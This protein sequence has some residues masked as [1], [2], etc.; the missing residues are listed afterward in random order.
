MRH[1]AESL[2]HVPQRGRLAVARPER[3]DP[4]HE[5]SRDHGDIA[6]G[7]GEEAPA[8]ADGGHQ[9]SGHG[10]SHDAGAVEGRRIQRDGV[11]QVLAAGHFGDESLARRNIEGVHHAE[12]RGEHENLP[13]LHDLEQGEPGQ[14][15][16]QQ[17]GS[18]LG[19][20]HDAMAAVPVGHQAAHGR[21]QKHGN[22]AGEIDRTQQRRRPGEPV[23]Q[24]GLRHGLHPGADQRNDLPRE[25][26]PE[27]AM[28]QRADSGAQSGSG[29]FVF[30]HEARLKALYYFACSGRFLRNSVRDN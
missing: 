13:H 22:L 17:H 4:H 20:D 16:G 1:E 15:A 21:E 24:P 18:D 25:E 11:D 8:L 14:R 5:Q 10:G 28:A 26:Q 9:D 27:V 12:Q 6:D 7:V 23:H 3:L 2:D 29:Y 30:R 19:S